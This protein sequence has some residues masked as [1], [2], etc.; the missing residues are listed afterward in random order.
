VIGEFGKNNISITGN[1]EN[2]PVLNLHDPRIFNLQN[3]SFDLVNTGEG[4][5]NNI[6]WE[7][8]IIEGDGLF[9]GELFSPKEDSGTIPSLGPDDDYPIYI[10]LSGLGITTIYIDCKYTMGDISGCSQEFEVKQ[11]WVVLG[12]FYINLFLPSM[13]PDKEWV[14]IENYSY[15]NDT[16]SDGVELIHGDLLQKHNTRVVEG[17]KSGETLFLA[18]CKFING[19]GTLRECG[20]TEDVVTSEEAHWEVELLDG[21]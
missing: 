3:I 15:F 8:N 12:I 10:E 20:I 13:Q 2:V 14:D 17:S 4:T 5:A 1:I 9:Y 21:E 18:T 19:T 7:M 16:K 6:T 11:E